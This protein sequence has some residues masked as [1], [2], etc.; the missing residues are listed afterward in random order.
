[1]IVAV[2]VHVD[3]LVGVQ[4]ELGVGVKDRVGV[5]VRTGKSYVDCDAIIDV[6]VLDSGAS[7]DI[8]NNTI[9]SSNSTTVSAANKAIKVREDGGLKDM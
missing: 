4:V 3:V 8:G 2:G 6:V 9:I 5:N 7:G 1:M